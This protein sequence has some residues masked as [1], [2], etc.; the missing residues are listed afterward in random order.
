VTRPE[1]TLLLYQQPTLLR[2]DEHRDLRLAYDP[3]DFSFASQ[4]NSF[5]LAAS[6][7]PEAVLHYPVVFIGS[8]GGPF[9]LAVLVGLTD[10]QNLSVGQDNRWQAGAYVPAFVRRY[11]FV[12]LEE[13][14]ERLSVGFDAG[15]PGFGKD[16]G[17]PLFD[18][19]G[20]PSALLQHAIAF[21]EGF[22]REMAA[23][24]DFASK[25][26]AMD[27]LVPRVVE[28][29]AG[30]SKAPR[31]LQGFYAVDADRLAALSPAQL[32]QL[33]AGPELSWIYLHL[34]S[35]KL[36]NR[37]AAG[38]D[39]RTA[40]ASFPEDTPIVVGALPG[41]GK[42]AVAPIAQPDKAQ[43]NPAP[44]AQQASRK[45]ARPGGKGAQS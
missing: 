8:E 14:P 41:T 4:S 7:I 23:T 1:K 20:A 36:V 24:Q 5:L 29:S 43:Q 33:A 19:A 26:A 12:L 42:P 37:L 27:L 38:V 30:P 6:E 45:A 13:A 9:S 18:G 32:A 31:T 35:L 28:L 22:H 10:R 21:L 25:L 17:E 15:Y 34:N 3:A 40:R 16:K 39:A 44:K 11:P 2:N